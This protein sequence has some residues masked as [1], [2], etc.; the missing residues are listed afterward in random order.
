MKHA[1]TIGVLCLAASLAWSEETPPVDG[2][3]VIRMTVTPQAPP[4]PALKYRFLPDV[5]QREPGNAML[6]YYLARE[7]MYGRRDHAE[8][9]AKR[10]QVGK[11]LDLAL[12]KL[13]Q[14]E[15]DL[16]LRQ[17]ELGLKHV[18]IGAK[19]QDSDLGLPL[20]QGF[21]LVLPSM[22]QFRTIAKVLSLRARQEILQ[23]RLDEGV[24]T[25][26]TGVA[27]GKHVAE[28][29]A[30][31]ICALV[32][33][34]IEEHMLDRIPELAAR[35]GPNLYWALADLPRPLI[36][37]RPAMD[38]EQHV[39]EWNILNLEPFKSNVDEAKSGPVSPSVGQD[40]LRSM[41]ELLYWG[42]TKAK[43]PKP[44][45]E[46]IAAL[47]SAKYYEVGKAGLIERGRSREEVDAMP[48]GQ[49]I[50]LHFLE[51]YYHWQGEVFKWFSLPYPQAWAG[52]T[53]AAQNFEKWQ[54][55]E[56]KDNA[57]AHFLDDVRQAYLLAAQ[58]DRSRAALQT[59]ES[60]R[61]YAARHGGPPDSLDALDLPAAEDPVTG[62]PF[63]YSVQGDTFVLVG[64]APDGAATKEG[65]RYE[66]QVTKSPQAPTQRASD[67]P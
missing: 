29:A 35:G 65:V 59:I 19:R 17:H 58:L 23:D 3:K 44:S 66:V 20:S 15:V 22:D 45:V 12:D 33:I 4:D 42:R 26:G 6:M 37:L 53:K 63:R 10:D 57:F 28:S 41:A 27:F 50:Y 49:V 31:T 7:I 43:R 47:L 54:E 32:G 38:A 13:P 64:P 67:T 11:Y 36:D 8:L 60:I 16:F 24:V 56:G 2:P 48:P 55:T 62:A 40:F 52:M 1:F 30:N 14:D 9:S 46:E 39:L 21:G 34:K 5:T 25:I 51:D 18:A 61:A